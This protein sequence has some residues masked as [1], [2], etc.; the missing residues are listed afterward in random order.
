MGKLPVLRRD[1]RPPGLPEMEER[2][3]KAR[4][5]ESTSEGNSHIVNEQVFQCTRAD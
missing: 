2:F 3:I 1:A 4:T 5:R